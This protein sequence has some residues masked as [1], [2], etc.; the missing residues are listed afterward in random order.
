[1]TKKNFAAPTIIDSTHCRVIIDKLEPWLT[2]L[3]YPAGKR[4][5]RDS[6]HQDEC[7]VIRKGGVSIHRQPDDM[8]IDYIV[9]PT[10]RGLLPVREDFPAI[11]ILK[12]IDESE[13]AILDKAVFYN[14]LS[15]LQ[16]WESFAKHLLEIIC[17]MPE[18]LARLNTHS[19]Y[20]SVRVQLIELM[21]KPIFIRESITAE[22]FIR[23]KTRA[24]RSSV[25]HILSNLKKGGYIILDNGI[26]KEIKSLPNRY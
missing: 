10:L 14:L 17:I 11:Y 25:M 7:Y 1:M 26:L 5:V 4:F 24:S 13:I 3:S 21:S 2:Y 12:T 8:L 19:V 15:E 6:N 9:A 23:E 20:E 16:L 22:K 18:V